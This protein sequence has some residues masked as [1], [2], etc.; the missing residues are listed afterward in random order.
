MDHLDREQLDALLNDTGGPHVSIILPAPQRQLRV[1]GDSASLRELVQSTDAELVDNWLDAPAADRLLE[2]LHQLATDSHF[3]T[4]RRGGV[5]IYLSSVLFR[6]YRLPE[7]VQTR[8]VV[9]PGFYLRPLLPALEQNP[10]FHLLT[11]SD[12]GASLYASSATAMQPVEELPLSIPRHRGWTATTSQ[13]STSQTSD[14][15]PATRPTATLTEV[16][17]E[18]SE[19]G[20]TLLRSELEEIEEAV[21]A[22]LAKRRGI[23]ILAGVDRLTE[24]YKEVSNFDRLATATISGN[25]DH[26]T[27]AQLF[28]HAMP[29]AVGQAEQQ[30]QADA[31]AIRERQ[32]GPLE[33]DAEQILRA[34]YQNRVQIL[35]FDVE[36]NLDGH[37][38]PETLTLQPAQ[39]TS[40]GHPN[41]RSDD[42]I[43]AAAVETLRRGGRVHAVTA[44]EMPFE[45]T[46]VAALKA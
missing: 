7:C 19:E 12:E 32:L 17:P 29:I 31:M 43:E 23:L 4:G 26:L 10:Q 44:D 5:A 35:F 45:T 36:A 8:L 15:D 2:P 25:V 21:S 16:S 41:Q 13:R 40:P 20:T 22:Y 3:T 34:A 9:A 18:A 27:P 6:V 37:F 33:T 38:C 46:L 24:R 1:N 14:A 42:L 30:R 39:P 11:L 28:Q